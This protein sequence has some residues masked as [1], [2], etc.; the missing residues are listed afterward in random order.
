[1]K[2]LFFIL[3]TSTIAMAGS[4]Q[5]AANE[6]YVKAMEALVPAW[7]FNSNFTLVSAGA[8]IPKMKYESESRGKEG[9][10]SS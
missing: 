3:L 9:V 5:T 1:M 4:S 6:K 8:W 7:S 10:K 2:K